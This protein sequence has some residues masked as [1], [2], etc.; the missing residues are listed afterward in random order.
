MVLVH[1][2]KIT[3]HSLGIPTSICR[4]DDL[5]DTNPAHLLSMIPC[6]LTW[7]MNSST[8]NGI[9]STGIVSACFAK[10]SLDHRLGPGALSRYR[11]TASLRSRYAKKH[12]ADPWKK[13]SLRRA[14]TK[15]S[16][17]CSVMRAITTPLAPHHFHAPAY[18]LPAPS[19]MINE[20]FGIRSANDHDHS[21]TND[22][23]Y[24]IYH[25]GS[26]RAR[27]PRC[28]DSNSTVRPKRRLGCPTEVV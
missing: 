13:A 27:L 8:D 4:R 5:T 16:A 10:I 20:K 2:S 7:I 26:R 22:H 23:N 6:W 28:P 14:K 12:C 21:Y 15:T 19:R 1:R 11:V 24:S 3:S 18:K 17:M 25:T 9:R